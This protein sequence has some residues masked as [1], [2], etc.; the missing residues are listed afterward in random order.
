MCF[1]PDEIQIHSQEQ[2]I[3]SISIRM[4]L[5]C[6]Y[7]INKIIFFNMPI[8]KPSDCVRYLGPKNALEACHLTDSQSEHSQLV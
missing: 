7:T 5:A 3:L 2:I 8:G 1:S 6:A 4:A